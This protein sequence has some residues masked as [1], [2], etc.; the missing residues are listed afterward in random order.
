MVKKLLKFLFKKRVYEKRYGKSVYNVIRLFGSTIV[1]DYERELNEV[2]QM[3]YEL[4]PASSPFAKLF[5][6]G[7][8][9]K[10]SLYRWND[11]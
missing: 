5:K 3:L 9:R 8:H 1:L 10:N 11:E 6:I 4:R 7:K 2:E